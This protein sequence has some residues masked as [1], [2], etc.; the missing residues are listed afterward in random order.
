[1]NARRNRTN[2]STV[3]NSFGPLR[4]KKISTLTLYWY[5]K[6]QNCQVS[7]IWHDYHTFF[8]HHAFTHAKQVFK[9]FSHILLKLDQISMQFSYAS[10]GILLI[11]K[12]RLYY[13]D[14][15]CIMSKVC[16]DLVE[17]FHATLWRSV[18]RCGN[19]ITTVVIFRHFWTIVVI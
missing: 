13:T 17:I 15:T 8:S 16:M 12:S 3:L 7:R 18:T 14:Q 10:C 19:F 2:L 5:T 4:Y 1:M 11:F 9:H 6:L